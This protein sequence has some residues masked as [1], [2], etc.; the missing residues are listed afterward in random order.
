MLAVDIWHPAVQAVTQA[1]DWSESARKAG[2]VYLITFGEND[3]GLPIGHNAAFSATWRALDESGVDIA[4]SRF[5]IIGEDIPKHGVLAALRQMGAGEVIVLDAGWSPKGPGHE[6][7]STTGDAVDIVMNLSGSVTG[8]L[9]IE[10]RRE[11]DIDLAAKWQAERMC[12]VVGL[13]MTRVVPQAL[14]R[15]LAVVFADRARQ[16]I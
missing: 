10:S 3:F 13:A 1:T 7:Q 11:P 4:G 9:G 16:H 15:D 5:L 8:E 14:S 6:E 12:E 2:L